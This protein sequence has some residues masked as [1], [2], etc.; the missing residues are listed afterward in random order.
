MPG[1]SDLI[2][3]EPI[4]RRMTGSMAGIPADEILGAASESLVARVRAACLDPGFLVIRLDEQTQS[5]IAA[6]IRQMQS[7]FGL[8][9]NHAIK[10]AVRQDGAR[11]GWQPRYSEPAY[12]PGTVSSLEA[13]DL[14][15][16]EVLASDEECW[17]D[18]P[19]FRATVCQCWER[20]L[21]L[22]DATLRLIAQAAGLDTDFLVDRCGTRELNSFRLLH[23]PEDVTPS[24]KEDVGISAHTDFE[25][26]TLLCQDSPGLELRA[27]DGRWIDATTGTGRI[28]VML[29]DMLER[30]TN[31]E[32]SAT[33]H[34]VR[35]TGKQR[36]SIV[37]F[38]AVDDGLDIAPLDQFTS[39]NNPP[40]YPP[41][42][43]AAHLDAEIRRAIENAEQD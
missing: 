31:G 22:A 15:I 34:R 41:V 3:S 36:F 43:Q 33:G 21:V 11:N 20:Y 13:Y 10:Q 24:S 5:S 38:M 26:I 12:Q 39:K 14:G 7:F 16:H 1:T 29:D 40:R 4:T 30:W 8:N 28:I 18:L 6:T 25:C 19:D 17:P 23:Y 37:M 2:Q 42:T 32:F 27:T 35:L 9:D